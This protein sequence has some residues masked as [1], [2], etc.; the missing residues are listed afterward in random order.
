MNEAEMKTIFQ[1]NTFG[2]V[3][4]LYRRVQEVFF[5]HEHLPSSL[6]LLT[7]PTT[8]VV[9]PSNAAPIQ[10]QVTPVQSNLASMVQA[11]PT[12]CEAPLD[13]AP[14]PASSASPAAAMTS[15]LSASVAVKPESN[16]QKPVV[17]KP[18]RLRLEPSS[19]AA[20]A[21]PS[22]YQ[23]EP[24][25]AAASKKARQMISSE[26]KK[27]D[28]QLS[29]EGSCVGKLHWVVNTKLHNALSTTRGW[30]SSQMEQMRLKELV[31]LGMQCVPPHT[32]VV[33]LVSCPFSL[34][35]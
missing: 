12:P 25:F 24:S 22:S 4:K 31:G 1:L 15:Q 34:H 29:A 26:E 10:L 6:S 11:E 17:I 16:T 13:P 33:V 21:A 35:T 5:P 18:E 32:T 20:A 28:D 2:K 23:D 19:S 9:P 27:V 8:I 3:R 14:L 30:A 7:P